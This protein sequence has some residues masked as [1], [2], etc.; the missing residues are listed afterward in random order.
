[1]E[2]SN[3]ILNNGA[4]IFVV[5]VKPNGE[6]CRQLPARTTTLILSIIFSTYFRH[7]W[8]STTHIQN[9]AQIRERQEHTSKH[10]SRLQERSRAINDLTKSTG[11]SYEWFEFNETKRRD[12]RNDLWRRCRWIHSASVSLYLVNA[13]L[14]PWGSVEFES[15]IV[16]KM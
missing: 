9:H 14:V 7:Q 6:Y 13:G 15:S 11:S 1:M 16:T 10:Q 8:C 4:L 3:R 5:R 2:R 12:Q